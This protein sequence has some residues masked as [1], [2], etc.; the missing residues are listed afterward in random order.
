GKGTGGAR[1]GRRRRTTTTCSRSVLRRSWKIVFGSS[2]ALRIDASQVAVRYSAGFFQAATPY[3]IWSIVNRALKH[4]L[5][6][7]QRWIHGRGLCPATQPREG[8]K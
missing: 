1:P 3:T 5:I 2:F 4:R 7:A 6:C 8:E